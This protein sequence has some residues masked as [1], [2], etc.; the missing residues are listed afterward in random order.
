LSRFALLAAWGVLLVSSLAIGGIALR[1]LGHERERIATTTRAAAMEHAD[2]VAGSIALAV[3]DV[4]RGLTDSLLRLPGDDLPAALL[5]WRRTNPL[6]RNAFVRDPAGRMVLPD[7]DRP[8]TTEAAGFLARY[9]SLLDDS[10]AWS[11]PSPDQLATPARPDAWTAEPA[12]SQKSFRDQRTELVALTASAPTAAADPG[13]R[14]G[15]IPWIWENQ[16]YLLGWVEDDRGR[17]GVELEVMALLSRLVE[18]IPEPTFSGGVLALLDDRGRILHQRG[19]AEITADTPRLASVP[20]G[21]ALPHWQVSIYAPAGATAPGGQAMVMLTGLVVGTFVCAILLG[22]ALLVWQAHRN[23][24]DA[25]QKTSFVS[26]VSHELKTPLTTIRMYAELLGENRVTEEAKRTRYL[27]VIVEESH[28][29]TR[30]VNNVLDFSRLEQGRKKYRPE[31]LDLWDLLRDLLDTHRLRIE[32]AGMRLQSDIPTVPCPLSTDRDAVEQALL[33]LL[34]NAIKYADGGGILTVEAAA[35]GPNAWIR[36]LDRGP[37]I[38]DAQR[39]LVFRKFH[40]VD[41]SLTA[42]RTGSGLGLTIARRLLRDLGGDLQYA[43]RDGG[44]ACFALTLPLPA[45]TRTDPEVPA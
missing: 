22:G 11:P 34:D 9:A 45:P 30:L 25:Q 44:G 31:S 36:V 18:S 14:S 10:L 33:N 7:P 35:Q 12:P 28:R 19:G 29:L 15:W 24:L 17:Y 4:Q 27:G 1:L 41:D 20:V 42:G 38:P 8:G 3:R 21:Q 23:L 37:G 5:A 16:L 39:E 6:V 43:P 26:N 2:A 40:R 32:R 13:A